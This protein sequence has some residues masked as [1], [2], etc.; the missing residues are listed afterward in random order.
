MKFT[1]KIFYTVE[2]LQRASNISRAA[3]YRLVNQPGFPKLKSGRRILIP[4]RKFDAWSE[5]QMQKS[6]HPEEGSH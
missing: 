1:E 3:A 5:A 6:T 2:E 4:A